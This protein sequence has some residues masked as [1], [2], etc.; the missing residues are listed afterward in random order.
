MNLTFR[1]IPEED[2]VKR[3]EEIV[4]ST[5]FFHDFETEVAVELIEERLK[6][7]EASGY[8][9]VFAEADGKTVAYTCYGPDPVTKSTFLLFWIVTHRDYMGKG[10][11][12][13]LLEETH[14]RVK[15]MGGTMIVAETS[16]RDM[17]APT[18]AFYS[19]SGYVP[20]AVIK[21]YYDKG[22][23][24]YIYVKRLN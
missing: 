23:D 24:K 12:R 14:S 1:T 18:R 20:E 2:D 5:G 22:D 19:K 21:D 6:E 7:G 3:I 17:Y 15:K 16:G 8:Y 4:S 11:G 10:I 9:F 13:R